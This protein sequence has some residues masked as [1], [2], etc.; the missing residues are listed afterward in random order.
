MLAVLAVAGASL[1][2]LL[3][4][5]H[6]GWAVTG[7]VPAAVIPSKRDGTPIID[8]SR[9]ESAV[10]AVLL[11]VAA[12]VHLGRGGVGPALLPHWA[13]VTGIVLVSIALSLRTIGDFRYV[14]LFKRERGTPFSR[15]DS[16]FYTPLVC[17]LGLLSLVLAFAGQ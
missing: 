7:R 2:A 15:Q 14:G 4:L 11:A 10:V 12:L 13:R 17:T 3:S 8:P 5:I 1:F 6:L 9:G 16:R